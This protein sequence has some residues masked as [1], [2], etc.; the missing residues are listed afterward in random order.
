V[1]CDFTQAL[2]ENRI[3]C[4]SQCRGFGLGPVVADVPE[5]L[6]VDPGEKS[7]A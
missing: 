4:R 7:N 2:T 5:V 6:L 1:K 3:V